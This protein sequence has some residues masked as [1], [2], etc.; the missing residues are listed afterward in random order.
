MPQAQTAADVW[1]RL[2]HASPTASVRLVCFP[3]AGGSASY[4][5]PL[6]AGLGPTVEALAVQY[7]GRQDRRGEPC[8]QTVGELADGIAA[9]LRPHVGQPLAFFGH[10]MGAV[11]AFEVTR[12]LEQQAESPVQILF[13]SGRRAP[14]AVRHETVHQG[15]DKELLAELRRLNGTDDRLIDDEE[16]LQMILPALRA[17]YRAIETYEPDDGASVRTPIVAL[18]GDADPRTTVEETDGWRRHTTGQFALH[19]FPGGHFYLDAERSNVTAT[20]LSHL[21]AR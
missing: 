6:S 14:S 4:Y 5:F 16:L 7:P 3:H 20:V 12:R 21:N 11:L 9:A 13:V 18:T 19:V 1:I 8:A 17:D 10:S 2:Y 15:G